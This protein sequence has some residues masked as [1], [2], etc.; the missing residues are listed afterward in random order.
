MLPNGVGLGRGSQCRTPGPGRAAQVLPPALGSR[1][2]CRPLP[3]GDGSQAWSQK[4][5]LR[6][7]VNTPAHL[8]GDPRNTKKGDRTHFQ[9]RSLWGSWGPVSPGT[10]R[11]ASGDSVPHSS[12]CARGCYPVPSILGQPC[13]GEEMLAASQEALGLP[14]WLRRA[15]SRGCR[16][17]HL[18]R[19]RPRAP[20]AGVHALSRAEAVLPSAGWPEDP[21]FADGEGPGLWD[22]APTAV[23]RL[24]FGCPCFLRACCVQARNACGLRSRRARGFPLPDA[25]QL[26]VAP[27]A[28][29]GLSLR[30]QW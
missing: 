1:G 2:D 8:E 20:A 24:A 4:P 15:R 28:K 23:T 30:P 21:R 6:Q 9:A 3:P 14:G 27:H 12:R 16:P 11:G 22:C 25:P 26:S 19:P 7:G 10:L 29:T 13:V 5:T 17:A 18:L